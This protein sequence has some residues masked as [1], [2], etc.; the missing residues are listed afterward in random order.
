MLN[1]LPKGRRVDP[2]QK[3]PTASKPSP[4]SAPLTDTSP[5]DHQPQVLQLQ[6]LVSQPLAMFSLCQLTLSQPCLSLPYYC[7]WRISHIPFSFY[8]QGNRLPAGVLDSRI[9]ILYSSLP[10]IS[11]HLTAC[12]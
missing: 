8:V 12:L 4:F 2:M 3:S 5:E 9:E 7:Y 10:E 1:N 11:D 6:Y